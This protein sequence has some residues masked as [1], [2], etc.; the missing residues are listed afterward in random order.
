MKAEKGLG[1]SHGGPFEW[2]MLGTLAGQSTWKWAAWPAPPPL[3]LLPLLCNAA[4]NRLSNILIQEI[5]MK[6]LGVKLIE[7]IL[8]F[9]RPLPAKVCSDPSIPSAPLR[10]A[11]P[12][13]RSFS[14]YYP[15]AIP[16]NIRLL[17]NALWFRFSFP[18]CW[19]AQPQAKAS[20]KIPDIAL[21]SVPPA[22]CESW[23]SSW[24]NS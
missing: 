11:P 22:S 4:D 5:E 2:K 19:F 23:P 16:Q 21:R 9:Q 13:F 24:S 7:N 8:H 12:P 10:S 6:L 3:L 1:G 15:I 20:S 18:K 14:S 17:F